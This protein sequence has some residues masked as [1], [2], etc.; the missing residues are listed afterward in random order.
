LVDRLLNDIYG[1]RELYDVLAAADRPLSLDDLDTRAAVD[2]PT[3]E[4]HHHVS[5]H[6]QVRRRRLRRL[7]GWFVLCDAVEEAAD[8][9]VIT[10]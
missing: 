1:A 6:E 3:W 2:L 8:G 5:D 7:V 9:Y 10:N 4:R